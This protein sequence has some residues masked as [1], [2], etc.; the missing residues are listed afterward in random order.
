MKYLVLIGVLILLDQISKLAAV[1][2]LR[3]QNGC[4]ALPGPLYLTLLYNRGAAMG[5]LARRPRL[6][7]G[8]VILMTALLLGYTLYRTALGAPA[9]EAVP[10]VLLAGGAVGNL[11]DRLRLGYVVDFLTLKIRKAP[12]FNLADL[13]ILVGAVLCGIYGLI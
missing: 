8:G 7:K 3:K 11:L 2:Q 1:K 9:G 4:I 5:L 6:L 12:V 13:F 10:L